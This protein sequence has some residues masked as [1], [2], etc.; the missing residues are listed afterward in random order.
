MSCQICDGELVLL[1]T[2]GDTI[3]ARC[4]H[5]GVDQ[6]ITE[7]HEEVVEL[8]EEDFIDPEREPVLLLDDEVF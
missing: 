3:Y 5:C 8:S 1:G 2:L 7:D 6:M 4:R